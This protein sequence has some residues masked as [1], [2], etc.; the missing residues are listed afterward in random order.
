MSKIK[1]AV[2][3]KELYKQMDNIKKD[4]GTMANQEMNIRFNCYNSRLGMVYKCIIN[5]KT[6]YYCV[7][8][9]KYAYSNLSTLKQ[10][11]TKNSM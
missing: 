10:Q 7:G 11:I 5:N 8:L 3:I 4:F 2:F 1:R 9:P 6:F